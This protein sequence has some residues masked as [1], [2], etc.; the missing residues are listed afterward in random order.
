MDSLNIWGKKTNVKYVKTTY[1]WG[2]ITSDHPKEIIGV[3]D[4]KKE[5]LKAAKVVLSSMGHGRQ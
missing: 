4:T 5:A 3:G 2:V 1:G